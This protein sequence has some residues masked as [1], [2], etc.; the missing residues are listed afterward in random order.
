MNTT[1]EQFL[2]I[3]NKLKITEQ[4][5]FTKLLLNWHQSHNNRSLP[6]KGETDAYKIWLSEIILQQTRAQQGIA[7]YERFLAHYPTVFH[8]AAATDAAAFKLWEGL[9][10]YNRCRN[11]LHTARV[12]VNDFEGVF[13]HTYEGLLALKGIGPYTAAAIASFA[14]NLPHAVLDGNV[15]R[16]L[17][18]FFAIEIA[19]DSTV[20]KQYFEQLV[21]QLLPQKQAALFNQAI[22]DFGATVCKPQIPSCGTCALQMHCEG[23][24]KQLQWK[25]PIKEKT[26]Q[27]KQ[28]VFQYWVLNYKQQIWV[29]QRTLPD[30]WQNLY[31]FLLLETKGIPLTTDEQ[32]FIA[33]QLQIAPAEFAKPIQV[34]QQLTHQQITGLF[35]EV[36][37]VKKPILTGGKWIKKA[38]LR[39]LAFPKLIHQYFEQAALP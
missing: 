19:T 31:E 33:Q 10:Y 1:N 37:L 28:R 23:F 5:F 14:Y 36:E 27:R 16:V 30:V 12:V 29:Q 34:R 24:A 7:Y 22:M 13:P 39:S 6:W 18:R 11:L 38:D 32:N 21:Q 8:L 2:L 35:Y 15:Y 9:G 3:V 20:G 25:L 4:H 26:I 17:A